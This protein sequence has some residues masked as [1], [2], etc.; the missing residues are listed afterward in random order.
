MAIS[1]SRREIIFKSFLIQIVFLIYDAGNFVADYYVRTEGFSKR[2]LNDSSKIA[3]TGLPGNIINGLHIFG[4]L[5]AVICFYLLVKKVVLIRRLLMTL[6]VFF[7]LLS[8]IFIFSLFY[9][10][11][12]HLDAF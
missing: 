9:L 8:E 6:I 4:L 7:I 2:I 3:P 12:A 11:S 1:K 10:L 5:S